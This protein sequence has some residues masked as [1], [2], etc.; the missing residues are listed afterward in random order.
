MPPEE[1][2]VPRFAAEPPQEDLPYG[3]WQERLTEEFLAAALRLEDEPEDLGEPGDVIWYPDRTLARAHLRARHVAHVRPAMSCSATSA[4]CPRDEEEDAREFSARVDFT[5]ETAERNPDWKLDLCEEVIGAWRGQFGAVGAMTLVW[6]RPL[7]SGGRI[8]TA[9]LADLAVDQ[10]ELVDERFT[11]IAPDDYRGDLLDIKLFDVKGRELARESL[12]A[13]EDEDE[14]ASSP[15]ARRGPTARRPTPVTAALFALAG[16]ERLFLLGARRH[17]RGV[18]HFFADFLG[19]LL[20]RGAVAFGGLVADRFE[21]G[22]RGRRKR[23][24]GRDLLLAEFDRLGGVR[25][26]QGGRRG[27]RRRRARGGR[28]RGGGAQMTW[29]CFRTRREITASDER[30]GEQRGSTEGHG[31][32]FRLGCERPRCCRASRAPWPGRLYPSP[33]EPQVRDIPHNCWYVPARK[34]SSCTGGCALDGAVERTRRPDN[35]RRTGMYSSKRRLAALGLAAGALMLASLIGTAGASAAS[36]IKEKW[37]TGYT[38]PGTPTA[39]D[40]VGVI[41]VGSSKA[42]NVLVIEPGTSGGGAYFIPLAKWLTEKLPGWQV[43]AVERRENLLEDQKELTKFKAGKATPAELFHYYLGYQSEGGKAKHFEPL[44]QTAA[45]ADG[46][47][48][49]G[50]NVAVQDLHIVIEAAKKLGEKHGGKVVLAGHSLGG[51]VVTA[52]ATWDFG[53]KPGADG[54]SGLV[55]I[56]GG[57]SPTRDQRGTGR[58]GADDTVDEDPVAGVRGNPVARPR[59]LLDA[60]LV[61]RPRGLRTK[62]PCWRRS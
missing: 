5:A 59:P 10:C 16:G 6:G 18:D 37:L 3:R 28:R 8:V 14:D 42:K 34:R 38:A 40:K 9:E 4:S 41:K 31:F 62:S 57:S 58:N 22:L 24:L 61:A 17:R 54:L 45:V 33:A 53:G 60:R 12:Y 43:W 1:R 35:S 20:H 15:R 26:G 36:L 50:M 32:P 47:R 23:G 27:R 49:W 2:F 25:A 48:E 52:Y 21:L 19:G 51:T 55:Y 30:G 46:G 11:L 13:G 29:S 39:L 7:I 44:T 56:D